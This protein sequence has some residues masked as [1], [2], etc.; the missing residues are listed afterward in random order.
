MLGLP[1]SFFQSVSKRTDIILNAEG[2]K[3][4]ADADFISTLI[5]PLQGA[6]DFSGFGGGGDGGFSGFTGGG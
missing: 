2:V 1:P 4:Q 6:G 3:A 5:D